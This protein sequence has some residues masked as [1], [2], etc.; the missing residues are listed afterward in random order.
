MN[1]RLYELICSMVFN[2]VI[3][4]NSCFVVA[5][6]FGNAIFA[7]RGREEG[8]GGGGGGG[9]KDSFLEIRRKLKFLFRS[10][11]SI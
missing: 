1:I 10:F 9:V 8:G 6:D 2:V 7:S 4:M 5:L 3:F 11:P